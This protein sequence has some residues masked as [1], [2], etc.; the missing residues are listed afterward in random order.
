LF[1]PNRHNK[2]FAFCAVFC[3]AALICRACLAQTTADK[4]KPAPVFVGPVLQKPSPPVGPLP[5][6]YALAFSLDGKTLAV[7]THQEALL[8]D[9]KSWSVCATCTQ[10]QNAVRCFSFHP[11]G[12]HVAIGSGVAGVSGSVTMWDTSEPAHAGVSYQPALDTIESIA[13]NNDGS[14]MLTASFD[15]KARLFPVAFYPYT[16]QELVEHNGRVTCVAFSPKPKYIFVT[17]AMDKMV[18][19]WDRKST[20]VVVNFDQAQAGITGVAFLSNGDQIVGASMDGNLYWWGVGYN[21][22]KKVYSGY[23]IRA[24]HAHD[25][26]V[27]AF[28]CS[29]NMQRLATG[30]MDHQVKIWKMDDGG[31]LAVFTEPTAPIYCTALSPDGK[32]AAAAGR[33]GTVWVWDVETK[34]L[35]TSLI[36][37]R[38]SAQQLAAGNSASSVTTHAADTTVKTTAAMIPAKHQ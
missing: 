27:T 2:F 10:I 15:S 23:Q 19:V 24:V 20:K 7:G 38:P 11:D 33:E 17:G 25:D 3:V 31:N 35:I 9:V 4:A 5:A 1:V 12:K 14:E 6:V 13:F 16:P 26:G 36:P 37:P 29:A 22:R 30:G 32:V 8:Y 21:E 28:S 18:K 34:K